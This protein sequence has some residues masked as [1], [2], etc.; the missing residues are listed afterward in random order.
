MSYFSL[1]SLCSQRYICYQDLHEVFSNVIIKYRRR[2][3]QSFSHYFPL[4]VNAISSYH[5]LYE[6]FSSIIRI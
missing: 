4:S 5:G 6:A 3:F 1:L 2:E